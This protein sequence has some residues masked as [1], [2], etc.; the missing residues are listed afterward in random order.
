M[1]ART[2]VFSEKVKLP[3]AIVCFALCAFVTVTIGQ[4]FYRGTRVRQAHTRLDFFTSLVGLVARNKRRYGGY[5]VHFGVVLM[6]LGF[7]GDA[8]KRETEVTLEKGQQATLGKYAV[9][10]LALRPESEVGREA[11]VADL[12]V[13]E[14]GKQV[15]RAQ[16]A[17]WYFP[18][19]EEEPVTHVE[20]RHSV[21]E[22][23]YLVLNGFDAQAGLVNLKIVVNPLVNWIWVGFMF[24][25]VGTA[26]AFAPE[27]AYLL[28]G[29]AVEGG[30]RAAAAGSALLLLVLL[31]AGLASFGGLGSA[32]A[33]EQHVEGKTVVAPPRSPDE[34]ELFHKLVCMCGCGRQLLA[35]CTCAR[36]AH[37]REEI[38]TQLREGK[39]KEQVIADYVAKFPGE[40]ALAMPIDRGFNR[41]AWILPYGA[42][43]VGIGG[44]VVAARRFTR[45]STG[46]GPSAMKSGEPAPESPAAGAGDDYEAR[47]DDELDDLD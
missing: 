27:R 31:G 23:L 33:Q 7:G 3:V 32:R 9:R 30:A 43:L 8:Y 2:A 16:P 10:F 22:D 47:L 46:A 42:L 11:V 17:K 39:N 40:S 28:A 34:N 12:D 25:A 38:S 44:L 1:A 15:A 29:A 35:D 6:F 20:M 18:H 24:L 13:F 45:P 4:E 41:L 37:A 26:I 5:L 21:R 14:S 19:H 36:A